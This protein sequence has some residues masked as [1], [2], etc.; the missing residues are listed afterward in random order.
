VISA[1]GAQLALR[2]RGQLPVPSVAGSSATYRNVLPGVDL[3]LTATSAAAGG[4]SEV[5]VVRSARA[6]RDPALARLVFGVTARGA[7]LGAAPDGGLVAPLTGPAT[8]GAFVAAAPRMWD[9][10]SQPAGARAAGMRAASAAAGPGSAARLAP[11]AASVGRGGANLALRPDLALLASPSTRF[12]VFIDPSFIF[13]SKTGAEQAFDPVQSDCPGSHYNDKADYP[14]SPVGFDNFRQGNCTPR[15]LA[16]RG[17]D[18]AR[19]RWRRL[20]ACGRGAAGLDRHGRGEGG[21]CPVA[22]ASAVAGGMLA[23]PGSTPRA[24][25][26]ARI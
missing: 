20:G 5:L 7:R 8:R 26:R 23:P 14:I 13:V 22:C 11:V 1:A 10:S 16:R 2:W 17:R 18:P 24:R 9:S 15:V 4:F 3:V 25:R 6:A 12:P 19:F 21:P